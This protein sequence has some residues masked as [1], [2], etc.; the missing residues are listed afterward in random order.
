M[1]NREQLWYSA[2]GRSVK[3]KDMT[4]GHLVN[5]INWVSDN[6]DSYPMSTLDVMI[7]EAE[8]RQLTLFAEAKAYPQVINNRWVLIDPKTGK[9]GI[10]PPPKEYLDSVKDNVAY[11]KMSQNTQIKRAK[12]R[13]IA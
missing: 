2:D 11:Q 1:H 7:A 5:V 10:I 6:K 12:R 3:I 13:N 8:Y 9:K 4:I